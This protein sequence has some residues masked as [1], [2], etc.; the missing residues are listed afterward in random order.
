MSVVEVLDKITERN[1]PVIGCLAKT[2]DSVYH[3][4]NDYDLNHDQILGN[5]DELLELAALLDSD[6]GEFNSVAAEFDGN[7]I[8]GQRIDEGTVLVVADHLPRAGLKKLQVGL[9]LQTRM[10]SKA[11]SESKAE[12]APSIPVAAAAPVAE[13][14][15]APAPAEVA[16]APAAEA[17]AEAPAEAAADEDPNKGKTKRVYRGQVYWV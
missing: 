8:I 15:P 4:L 12:P 10:L 3:N 9:A 2:G 17:P 13:A 11:L 6:A 5:I 7:T 16:P 14:A 1:N